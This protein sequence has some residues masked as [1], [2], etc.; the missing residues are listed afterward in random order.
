MGI[1]K[2][3]MTKMGV[4]R[5]KTRV[6]KRSRNQ[7][8]KKKFNVNSLPGTLKDNWDQTMS[9]KQNFASFGLNTDVNKRFRHSKAGREVFKTAQNSVFKNKY[10]YDMALSD[11]EEDDEALGQRREDVKKRGQSWTQGT[12]PRNQEARGLQS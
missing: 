7:K 4:K 1:N 8:Q 11:G 12:L 5:A 9:F 2:N 10:G 3:K 6:V